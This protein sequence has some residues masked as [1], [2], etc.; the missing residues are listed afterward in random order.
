MVVVVMV[1]GGAD[2]PGAAV[3]VVAVSHVPRTVVMMV[4]VMV[5]V[6]RRG[7]V[8]RLDELGW[9]LRLAVGDPQALD[10]VGDRRQQLGV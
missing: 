5:M 10:G 8:L 3:P 2:H 1:V 7:D 9:R 4:V 6:V